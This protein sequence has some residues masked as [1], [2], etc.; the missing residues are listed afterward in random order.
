M[1]VNA[2]FHLHSCFSMASSKDMIIRNMAPKAKLKGLDLLGT[3]D[4]LH[5]K[6]LDII[7]DTT[8]YSGDG[9]YAFDDMDF[10]L[11]TEVEGRNRIHHV[12][13]IPDLDIARE[14]SERLPSKNKHADGRPKTNLAFATHKTY[15]KSQ[16]KSYY[17]EK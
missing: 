11:T 6:W 17:Q 7:E 14:L 15:S 1:L 9:I 12:I 3:G 13:I 5:P 10:I 8:T 16:C 4:A 2:D